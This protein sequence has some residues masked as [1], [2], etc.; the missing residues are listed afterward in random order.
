MI[1]GYNLQVFLSSAFN[2]PGEMTDNDIEWLSP[3]QCHR[4]CDLMFSLLVL[5]V[6]SVVHARANLQFEMTSLSHYCLYVMSSSGTYK[7]PQ[8]HRDNQDM[9]TLFHI[10]GCS[11]IN[12]IKW[13]RI[14]QFCTGPNIMEPDT[15]WTHWQR[16]M[17]LN[18]SESSNTK[19]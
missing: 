15:H 4:A 17:I 12:L 14:V 19:V 8:S 9:T 10:V 1:C 5:V 2:R 16:C 18:L 6:H 13:V 3:T 11:D 7:R